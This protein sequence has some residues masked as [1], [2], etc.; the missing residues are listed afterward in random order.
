MNTA[1]KAAVIAALLAHGASAA[2]AGVNDGRARS[3]AEILD[4]SAITTSVKAALLAED[5][6]HFADVDV[7]T[8]RRAVR[9]SGSVGSQRHVDQAGAAA[10]AVEGVRHV[11]N[12]LARESE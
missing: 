6:A 9:L 7:S 1:C 3:G 8:H 5:G 10:A 11:T 12:D 4:D 2:A